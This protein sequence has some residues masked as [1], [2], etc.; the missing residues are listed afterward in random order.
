MTILVNLPDLFFRIYTTGLMGFILS[1]RLQ[2]VVCREE[3]RTQFHTVLLYV[4]DPATFLAS[5]NV[6]CP[7]FS[8]R[9]AC[10]LS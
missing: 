7:F 4:A 8:L 10:L 5:N 1:I 6:L 2:C 3:M 9:I